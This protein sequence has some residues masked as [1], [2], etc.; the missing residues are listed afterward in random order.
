MGC[1]NHHHIHARFDQGLAAFK[2]RIAHG[3]GGSNAQAAHLVFA[4]MGVENRLFGVFQR[5]KPRQM[6][7]RIG[8]EQLFNP[9]LLHQADGRSAVN[10]FA[11][12]SQIVRGHH[13]ADRRA[14][15]AG[16]AHIAV[17]HN[18][19]HAVLRINNRKARD[20]V[21]VHQILGI[22][23]GLIGAQRDGRINHATFKPLYTA[24]FTGLRF[25]VKVAVD[26]PNPARLR[27]SNRHA[28]F[29]HSVHRRGQ[30]G[31]VHP[32]GFRHKS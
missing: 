5:Q 31:Y 26:H 16:K 18:A 14:I 30:K 2:A 3:C 25:K 1:V 22:G 9:A 7:L 27:H 24:H 10:R 29:G 11:Q 32:D 28:R 4:G 8:H 23:K 20:I 19:H 6:A 17:G 21:A 15:V 13:G 12:Q